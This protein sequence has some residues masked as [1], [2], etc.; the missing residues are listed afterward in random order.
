MGVNIVGLTFDE[1]DRILHPMSDPEMPLLE[2]ELGRAILR[3]VTEVIYLN[4][5]QITGDLAKAGI[6]IPD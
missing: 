3:K 5:E 6:V 1:I 2:S 4:N